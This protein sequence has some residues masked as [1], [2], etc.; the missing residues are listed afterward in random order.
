LCKHAAGTAELRNEEFEAVV[1]KN[2]G[3]MSVSDA[4]AQQNAAPEMLETSY[5]EF[6]AWL[7]WMKAP[8]FVHRAAV[9]DDWQSGWPLRVE[10]RAR[11]QHRVGA[12][13]Y[14]GTELRETG[15][16][17]GATEEDVTLFFPRSV[18]I[19]PESTDDLRR[20]ACDYNGDDVVVEDVSA[21]FKRVFGHDQ[22]ADEPN[23]L[24]PKWQ[25]ER[26]ADNP[27]AV[28]K[29]LETIDE[30]KARFLQELPTRV[31]Y[32]WEARRALL[33]PLSIVTA[34][35]LADIRGNAL[36][37]GG[38]KHDSLELLLSTLVCY[39]PDEMFDRQ[40]AAFA[41]QCVQ[42]EQL[43]QWYYAPG[44]PGAEAALRRVRSSL[45]SS[46]HCGTTD[47]T[48]TTA[49]TRAVGSG[50]RESISAQVH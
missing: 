23:M 11:E 10:Q 14:G 43:V 9:P 28:R 19:A 47:T 18:C 4:Q 22:C 5:G 17:R 21:A 34:E 15:A 44:N 24:V 26:T 36:A 29:R 40:F 25:S 35:F 46:A 7:A 45:G 50:A 37:R 16:K 32:Q 33:A 8:L 39:S 27:F 38:K 20:C 12:L 3:R 42:L 41:A 13:V 30:A 6:S 48:I 1:I 49:T 2:F 31:L